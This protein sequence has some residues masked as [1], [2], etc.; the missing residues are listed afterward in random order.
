MPILQRSEQSFHVKSL[1]DNES[2]TEMGPDW[3]QISD[4]RVDLQWS[5]AWA[6]EQNTSV[7]SLLETKQHCKHSGH[8]YMYLWWGG[9]DGQ[10]MQILQWSR[11]VNAF[12]IAS[13]STS[14][15]K[16]RPRRRCKGRK[17]WQS[18][19]DMLR[20]HNELTQ[21]AG[22]VAAQDE[23]TQQPQCSLWIVDMSGRAHQITH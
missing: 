4:H 12:L 21:S 1:P 17:V 13:S 2:Y 7:A 14:R 3:P 20:G 5:N 18:T 19:R 23:E 22:Q 11:E 8:K 16:Q 15:A 10:S 9:G 6:K